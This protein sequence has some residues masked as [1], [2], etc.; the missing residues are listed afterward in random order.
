MP[1]SPPWDL[2]GPAGWLA[3]PS[4]VSSAHRLCQA[5]SHPR[6][7]VPG[8]PTVWNLPTDVPVADSFLV[9]L[10]RSFLPHPNPSHHRVLFSSSFLSLPPDYP[11]LLTDLPVKIIY[12]LIFSKMEALIHWYPKCLQRNLL[13]D[14]CSV[15]SPA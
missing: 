13:Q 5:P 2:E 8:S 7:L 11:H 9:I 15:N 6:D 1:Q 14:R 10:K 3:S 4:P 12:L